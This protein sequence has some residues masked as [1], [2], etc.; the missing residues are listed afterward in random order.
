MRIEYCGHYIS[1]LE[2]NLGM[3]KLLVSPFGSF[4]AIWSQVGAGVLSL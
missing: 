1:D 3:P 2:T 4:A